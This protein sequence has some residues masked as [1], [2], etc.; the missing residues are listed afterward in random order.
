[1][2]PIIEYNSLPIRPVAGVVY[3]KAKRM[4]QIGHVQILI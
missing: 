2:F 3:E 1:M 4:F